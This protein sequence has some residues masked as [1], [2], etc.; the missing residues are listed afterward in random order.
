MAYLV[1]I[2]KAFYAINIIITLS[3][4]MSYKLNEI[5]F[6]CIGSKMG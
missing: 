6:T 4:Q 5:T 1:R 2:T 3:R